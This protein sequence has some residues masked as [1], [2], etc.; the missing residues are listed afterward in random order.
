MPFATRALAIGDLSH[1]TITRFAAMNDLSGKVLQFQKRRHRHQEWI[2][3][4]GGKDPA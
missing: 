3:F 4:L 1:G 2:R